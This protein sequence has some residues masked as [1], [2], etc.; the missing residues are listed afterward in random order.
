MM[1]ARQLAAFVL[2]F[3]VAPSVHAGS[4]SRRIAQIFN[5]D[6]RVMDPPPKSLTADPEVRAGRKQ[7]P[8]D[9][10]VDE[11]RSGGSDALATV[12]V[13]SAD[14]GVARSRSG[15]PRLARSRRHGREAA[16]DQRI[17]SLGLVGAGAYGIFGAELEF[18]FSPQ[19]SGGL[20]IGTGMAYSS[21]GVFSRYSFKSGP[22]TPF[23][24][25]GY[26][27]WQVAGKPAADEK[28]QPGYLA[29]RFLSDKDGIIP[30]GSAH[31]IY[32]GLGVLFQHPSGIGVMAQLQYFVSAPSFQGAPAGSFGF[33]YSF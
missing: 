4:L 20:G 15:R 16:D 9:D 24:Q 23:F 29:E 1:N 11:A 27:H 30:N 22:L 21:W 2:V 18:V 19:W 14:S 13:E 33:Y 17:V 28:V 25:M 5:R 3:A 7:L 8:S 26:A 6:E 12:P 31:I 32:P 10:E